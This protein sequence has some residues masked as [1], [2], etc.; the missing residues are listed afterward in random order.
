MKKEILT[1]ISKVVL[2]SAKKVS[3]QA[4]IAYI[5]QPKAPEALKKLRK[6]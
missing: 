1:S 4:C 5:Y 2:H 6:F 3:N